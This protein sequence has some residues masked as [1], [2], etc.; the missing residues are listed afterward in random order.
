MKKLITIFITILL[1]SSCDRRPIDYKNGAIVTNIESFE[2]GCI[3][4]TNTTVWSGNGLR[5][6]EGY[7]CD[8]CGKFNIGDTIKLTK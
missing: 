6:S 8:K 1:L 2:E 7:F 5:D 3:Y 4:Y